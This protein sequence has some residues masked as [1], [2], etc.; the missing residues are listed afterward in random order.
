MGKAAPLFE[1][2]YQTAQDEMSDLSVETLCDIAGVSRSG[3]Y[4]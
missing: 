1:I 3:Y 4:A 2:I